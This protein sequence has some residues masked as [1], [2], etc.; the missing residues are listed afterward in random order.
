[1]ASI[2]PLREGGE[3][4]DRLS[5]FSARLGMPMNVGGDV[6]GG[7]IRN[8]DGSMFASWTNGG[9]SNYSGSWL[10]SGWNNYSGSWLNSGWNNYSGN[11][12]NSGWNN[13]SGSWSNGG[14]SNYSGGK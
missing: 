6:I 11:W 7:S 3:R 12:M 5:V 2:D 13:Y 1:M 10:N 9:W 4:M 8:T 14:W